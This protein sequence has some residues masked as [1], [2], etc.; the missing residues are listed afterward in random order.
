ML[1]RN[2]KLKL[3]PERWQES[4]TV[5]DIVITCEE[6]CFDAVVDDLFARGGGLNRPVHVI[7]IEIR[8][9]HEQALIAGKALLEL[10][11]AIERSSDLAHDMDAILATQMRRHPHQ[12]L[13][14]VAYY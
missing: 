4:K 5:A 11:Q 12:L 6:R 1:D 14:T 9:S 10:C 13:H 7:N 2:R 8:D 3:A